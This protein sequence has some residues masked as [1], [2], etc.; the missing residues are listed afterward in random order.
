ML[1]LFGDLHFRLV[2]SQKSFNHDSICLASVNYTLI[3]AQQITSEV[4][5]PEHGFLRA[6]STA[7]F[8]SVNF[9]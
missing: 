7:Q 2:A 1:F 9:D 6:V 4:L 3:A 8:T 5:N